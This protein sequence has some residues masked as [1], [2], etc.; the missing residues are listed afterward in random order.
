VHRSVLALA[1]AAAGVLVATTLALAAAPPPASWLTLGTAVA[2]VLAFALLER[3]A[4]AFT[5]RGHKHTTALTEALVVVGFVLLGAPLLVLLTALVRIGLHFAARRPP[6]KGLFNVAQQVVAVAAGGALFA[7]L[8]ALGTAPILAALAGTILYIAIADA[9]TATLFGLIESVS[10]STV[11]RER[12]APTSALGVATGLPGGIVLFALHAMHPLA[13]LAAFPIFAILVR[14]SALA[15][16][17]DVELVVRRRLAEDARH[18]IGIQD[19]E[20]I[21]MHV[22]STGRD[23]LDAGRVRLVMADGREWEQ[24]GDD[25]A[26]SDEPSASSPLVGRDGEALGLLSA[27]ERRAK[28]AFGDQER[29]LLQLLAG[30]AS[31]TF[32]SARALAQVAA[33]RDLIARQEK[34]SALGTLLAGVAHEVNNPLSFM[35]LR[36]QITRAEAQKVLDAP[37]ASADAKALARKT[38]DAADVMSRGVERLAGL[39]HSLKVVARPGD[40]QRRPTQLNDVVQEVMTVLRAVEKS[41][42]YELELADAMPLVQANAAELHQVLL[43]LTKN[44]AEVLKDREGA[45]IRVATRVDGERA[46]VVVE[47]NGPGIP[48]E[49]QTRMFTP[50]FTTKEKGTGLGLSI[51]HQIVNAHGGTLTFET[52]ARGTTFYVRIPLAAAVPEM[53]TSSA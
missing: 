8:A 20:L 4:V 43:N 35:R 5:W 40:G 42:A 16:A 39:S 11:W 1:I 3:H 13:L 26:G 46:L 25:A 49:V 48:P 22:L 17:S 23:L 52:G 36:V 18:L 28:R 27:W 33:Q 44:A 29:A 21:A 45:R 15:A 12:L 31:A 51:S 38:L 41:V 24:R 10:P 34:L 32:E 30:Q 47:D 37:G 50:F 6:I 9:L 7:W 19:E 53:P 14:A 2:F